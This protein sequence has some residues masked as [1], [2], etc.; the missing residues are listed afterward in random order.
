[1]KWTRS[2][3]AVL[4]ALNILLLWQLFFSDYGVSSYLQLRDTFT[5]YEQKIVRQE[6]DNQR[7]SNQIRRIRSDANYQ[8]YIVR[9]ERHYAGPSE[10]MYILKK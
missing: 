6:A 9:K 10:Y 8:E 5:L 7:I 2:V 1:M 4:I 3:F